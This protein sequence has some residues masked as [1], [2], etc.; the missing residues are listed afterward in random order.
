MATVFIKYLY[1]HFAVA[2]G[3]LFRIMLNYIKA[4]WKRFL[5]SQHFKTLFAPWRRRQ[6]SDLA[7]SS[8]GIGEKIINL[9]MDGYIRLLAAFVRSVIIFFGLISEIVVI[10]FFVSVIILWPFWPIIALVMFSKGLINFL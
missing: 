5:I 1:W 2:P 8:I 7:K 3:D 6:P 10:I 9:I 4:T